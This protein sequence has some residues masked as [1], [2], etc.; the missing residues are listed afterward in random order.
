MYSFVETDDRVTTVLSYIDEALK[1]LEEMDSAVNSYK[2]HLNVSF[3]S[4]TR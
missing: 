1:E 3:V 2:V 4:S